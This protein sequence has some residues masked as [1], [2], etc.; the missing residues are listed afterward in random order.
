MTHSQ[1][2]KARLREA[3]KRK[4]LPEGKFQQVEL[5]DRPHPKWMTR[6]YA[7]NRYIVMVMDNAETDKGPAIRAMIQ[8]V[9]DRPIQNHWSELQRIKNEIFGEQVTAIEYFPPQSELVDKHN[10]YWIWIFLDGVLPKIKQP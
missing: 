3:E 2:V 6:A 10:I 9:D 4:R 7:N 1:M 5:A 8:T